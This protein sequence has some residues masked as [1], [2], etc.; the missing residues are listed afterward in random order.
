MRLNGQFAKA[1]RIFKAIV[2]GAKTGIK[3]DDVASYSDVRSAQVCIKSFTSSRV[4]LH[5]DEDIKKNI[6]FFN[7]ERTRTNII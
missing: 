1:Q 3:S 2:H 5:Q 4:T 6:Y 7:K